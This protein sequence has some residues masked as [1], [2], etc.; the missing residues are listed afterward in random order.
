MRYKCL[1]ALLLLKLQFLTILSAYDKTSFPL[2]AL[3]VLASL[4][5]DEHRMTVFENSMKSNVQSYES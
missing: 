4:L 2:S 1:Y 5:G 3:S